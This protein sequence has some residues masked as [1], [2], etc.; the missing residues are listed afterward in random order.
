MIKKFWKPWQQIWS[1]NVQSRHCT[2][3]SFVWNKTATRLVFLDNNNLIR[4]EYSPRAAL[5]FVI[6][7]WIVTE[8]KCQIFN[9]VRSW[10]AHICVLYQKSLGAISV[11]ESWENS[12]SYNMLCVCVN[13]WHPNFLKWTCPVFEYWARP[14][15]M[16]MEDSFP[17]SQV[18]PPEC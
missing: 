18:I 2:Y 12:T 4:L 10:M 5:H 13:L 11:F 14:D 15:S 6:W 1:N 17:F 7:F 3:I 8:E 16:E 9:S